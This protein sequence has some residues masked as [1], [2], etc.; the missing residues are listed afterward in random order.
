M[1]G[2]VAFMGLIALGVAHLDRKYELRECNDFAKK[3]DRPVRFVVDNPLSFRCEAKLS[4]GRWV[5]TERLY[6]TEVVK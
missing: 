5:D 4:D 3:H 1:V 2:F 6:L